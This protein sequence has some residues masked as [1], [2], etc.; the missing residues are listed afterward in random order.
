MQNPP[1]TFASTFFRFIWRRIPYRIPYAD[2][3]YENTIRRV[4]FKG[5]RVFV[6]YS[7]PWGILGRVFCR[8]FLWNSSLTATF[9]VESGCRYAKIDYCNLPS[10]FLETAMKQ[11]ILKKQNTNANGLTSLEWVAAEVLQL[12]PYW[13]AVWATQMALIALRANI[14]QV[15]P[16]VVVPFCSSVL[17]IGIF[18]STEVWDRFPIWSRRERKPLKQDNFQ[19]F[20]AKNPLPLKRPGWWITTFRKPPGPKILSKCEFLIEM[21]MYSTKGQ[22]RWSGR[23]AWWCLLSRLRSL[24]GNSAHATQTQLSPNSCWIS[25]CFRGSKVWTSGP[26]EVWKGAQEIRAGTQ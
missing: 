16:D 26:G 8:V 22:G 19:F 25:W 24:R 20:G 2:N 4:F 14:T 3:T 21:W 12:I 5:G 6:G 23:A 7:Y 18:L 13:W 1:H 9:V 10:G 17:A 11:K 15:S